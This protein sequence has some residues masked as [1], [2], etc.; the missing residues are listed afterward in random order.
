PG[1]VW[2]YNT[3]VS[4]LLA[5]LIYE[6]SGFTPLEFAYRYVFGP[7]GIDNV[8]WSESPDGINYGGSELHLTPRDLAKFGYLFLNN[9]TWDGQQLVSEMWVS[10]ST[11]Q[12]I[13][14]VNGIGYGYQWWTNSRIQSY[15]ARGLAEQRLVVIPEYNLVI[16]FTANLA[17]EPPYT[18][19][20][21]EYI[22]PSIGEVL[23]ARLNPILL[24]ALAAF[25]IGVPTIV[26][27][28]YL[29]FRKKRTSRK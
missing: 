9:G 2:L 11:Q 28:G 6:T 8:Y 15:E 16:V 18:Y 24:G 4:Y 5:A 10:E 29:H 3:G 19:L 13:Y 27:I 20:I 26:G 25:L 22:I 23:P 17:E 12:A 1:T 14:L 7:L 21:E